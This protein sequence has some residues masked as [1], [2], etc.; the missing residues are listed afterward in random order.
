MKIVEIQKKDF[1]KRL[2]DCP[3]KLAFFVASPAYGAHYRQR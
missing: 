2:S 1:K 3:P